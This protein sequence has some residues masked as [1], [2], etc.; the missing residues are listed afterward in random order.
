MFDDSA[1]RLARPHDPTVFLV[2]PDATHFLY[3]WG[4]GFTPPRAPYA[5]GVYWLGTQTDAAEREAVRNR[6][7]DAAAFDDALVAKLVA[8]LGASG[9]FDDTTFV[10]VGD[11]GEEFW[12][13]GTSAHG[14]EACAAQTH[15][16]LAI[17]PSR[18][19]RAIDPSADWSKKRFASAIDVWPT[20]L[21][22]AGV[23][24]DASSLLGGRSLLRGPA[25]PAITATN[26]AFRS[27]DCFV[28]DDG[29]RRV[30]LALA[31]PDHPEH[32]QELSVLAIRNEEDSARS[33]RTRRP[34]R[35]ARSSARGSA[36]RSTAGS[37]WSGRSRGALARRR[38]LAPLGM[39]SHRPRPMRSHLA[40][41]PN[42]SCSART[43]SSVYF[44]ATRQLILISLVEIAWMLMPSSARM[45]EH[46][47]RDA[48]V[49]AHA[50]ADDRDLHDVLVVADLARAERLA[51]AP[52]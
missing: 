33:P 27:P 8:S 45:L 18:A 1:S 52:R 47:R 17:R 21:D 34:A 23:R 10:V 41:S 5:D 30:E 7:L 14:S 39:T 12:E 2:S 19:L 42:P 26:R 4:A 50:E 46:L 3:W 6:Y 13:H 43:A 25:L 29:E 11:H 49:R 31:D 44:A 22:A 24:G 35:P 28:L 20:L 9:T 51:R 36:R 16:P 15:V 37:R 48:G 40:A 38:S 32:A